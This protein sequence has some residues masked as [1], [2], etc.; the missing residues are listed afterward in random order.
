MNGKTVVVGCKLPNGLIIEVGSPGEDNYWRV[1][2][3]GSNAANIIGGYGIT[4]NVDEDNF[5]KWLKKHAF[6]PAVKNGLIFVHGTV[7]SARD[8]ALERKDLKHGFEA[9]DPSKPPKGIEREAARV[10]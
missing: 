5:A 7:E 8:I 4:E 1:Q 10:A 9:V 3:K 6:M 2:L